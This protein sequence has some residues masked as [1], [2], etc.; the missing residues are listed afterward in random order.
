MLSVKYIS[1][2]LDNNQIKINDNSYCKLK[3]FEFKDEFKNMIDEKKNS[4]K[5]KKNNS[6]KDLEDYFENYFEKNSFGLNKFILKNRNN[7]YT[8]FSCILGI[9]DENYYLLDESEKIK[10][11]KYLIKTM[12][13]DLLLK[14]YYKEFRYDK[15]KNFN[16]EKI[17][18]ALKDSFQ[19]KIQENFDLVRKYAV[20]YLGINVY[21]FE[22]KDNKIINK[23]VINSNK[24]TEEK[25][26]YL[27]SY[28]IIKENDIYIPIMVKDKE[29]INYILKED[30][31]IINK[32]L[33]EF[34][35][36]KINCNV[37]DINYIKKM[38]IDE[39][40]IYCTENNIYIY[41]VS[42]KTGKDIRKTKD[43]LLSEFMK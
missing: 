8:F 22:I 6:Y 17:M 3:D 38:K 35:E 20:D 15:N 40:R 13:D 34:E 26:N 31:Y 41:K 9:G 39:L 24:Y 32:R 37:M 27:P 2:F 10:S 18:S 42:E 36:I 19:M 21:I 4:E 7:V 12:D 5:I 30:N 25:N 11:I 16:K 29:G 28:F 43:E 23:Y 33:E 1:N 14:N